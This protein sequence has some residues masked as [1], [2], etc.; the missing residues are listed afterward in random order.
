M[1][2]NFV[3]EVVEVVLVPGAEIDKG[4]NGLIWIR[5]D[6]LSLGF[7]HNLKHVISESC[8]VSDAIVDVGGLVDA[9]EGFIKYREEVTEEL[10]SYGLYW[11]FS[12]YLRCFGRAE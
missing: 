12:I 4:L 1:D 11:R 6:I 3:D 7:L 10:E 5:R 2:V 9:D 8:K